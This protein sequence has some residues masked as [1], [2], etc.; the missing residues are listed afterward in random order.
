MSSRRRHPNWI[1]ARLPSGEQVGATLGVLR[2]HGVATVCQEAQ[3]PNLGECFDDGTATFMIMGRV[4]SRVCG[5]C[6]VEH[7]P[8]DPLDPKEPQNVARA[9]V[10]MG[11][12]HVVITS[13]TRDD[14]PDGGAAHFAQC[15][16]AVKAA[17]PDCS[18]EVLVPDFGGQ[19]ESIER[20]ADSPIDVLNH[21]VETVPRLYPTVRPQAD[22][23]RSITLLERAHARR[24]E[25][26]T[27]SGLMLGLGE[28]D[29]EIEQVLVRLHEA[30]C[31]IITLGQYLQ[32]TRKQLPVARYLTPEEF[33]AWAQRARAIGFTG[34]ASA[35]LVRSSYRAGACWQDVH[36]PPAQQVQ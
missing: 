20:V 7:G 31:S 21:N 1:R 5:Y 36:S 32:P 18:V 15:A 29:E 30:G 8:L 28:T 27:K 22:F 2:R 19:A 12:R 17:L 35:P 6:A 26:A 9:A 25:L 24:P 23:E 34:V 10:E 11:L 16:G 33:A 3:C 13:V 14:L 4:C